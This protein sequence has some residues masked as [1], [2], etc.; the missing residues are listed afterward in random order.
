MQKT[1]SVTRHNI[2]QL[3]VTD[4]KTLSWESNKKKS[5]ARQKVVRM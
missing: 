1:S 4:M 2:I 3:V 5:I